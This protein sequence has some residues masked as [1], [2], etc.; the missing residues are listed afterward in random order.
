MNSFD[1]GSVGDATYQISKLFCYVISDNIFKVLF[2]YSNLAYVA[3]HLR[4]K[5]KEDFNFIQTW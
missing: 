4:K 5:I 2:H 3:N 1:K